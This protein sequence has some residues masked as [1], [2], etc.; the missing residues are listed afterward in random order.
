[1]TL[2]MT[3]KAQLLAQLDW[4]CSTWLIED[5][6]CCRCVLY[7]SPLSV[8]YIISSIEDQRLENQ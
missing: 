4:Y 2:K 7:G 6:Q 1:M 8:G 3:L 5:K